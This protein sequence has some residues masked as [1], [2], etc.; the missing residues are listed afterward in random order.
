[1]GT[2]RKSNKLSSSQLQTCRPCEDERVPDPDD[3]VS[4][5]GD[6]D[7]RPGAVVEAVHSF[8]HGQLT[9]WAERAR[10]D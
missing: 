5:R 3:F 6:D 2:F 8:W 9:H 1:M 7:V 4:S 10:T